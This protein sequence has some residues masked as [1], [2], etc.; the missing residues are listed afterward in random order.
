M[1][2]LM[3][4]YEFPPLGG[5]ASPAS[6]EIAKRYVR[7]GHT[8]DV[9]TMAFKNLPSFEI[10]EGINIYRIRCLRTKKEICYPWE[11]LSYIVSAKIF[12]KTFLKN[13]KYDINHTHFIIP[14]GLISLW[15]KKNY[16]LNYIITSHGS[17]VLGYNKR[18]RF[19]YPL[20]KRTWKKIIREADVVTTPSKFLQEKIKEHTTEGNFVVIPYTIDPTLF[21]PL[22][23]EKKILIVARLFVNKG[24]QDILQA[25][26]EINM[27]GWTVDIIGDGPY[28][29]FL[30]K[31]AKEN[32]L[33]T[34][35]KFHG[36]IDNK[37]E[38]MKTFYGNAAIFI[39]ASYFESM[40][41]TVLE[42]IA[43]G[44]YALVTNVGGHLDML[45][46]EYFF[47]ASNPQ[48]LKEKLI[49]LMNNWE[50]L[51][52]VTLD[53]KFNWDNIILRYEEAL[54]YGKT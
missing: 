37:S 12:L 19:I 51:K 5:G 27:T 49:P 45:T 17:D 44:C 46:D 29:N 1:N 39:S 16:R 3:L 2:I 7:L 4:N 41:L 40:G 21:T 23:K 38:V 31:K 10:K 22:S 9:V 24:V 13:K 50:E 15:V 32:G 14:T 54:Q 52:P 34:V 6:Y 48:S 26:K 53:D 30:E 25:M 35:V 36:W 28:R 47:E 42:A 20:I 33:E 18:F 8:V 11:Q 43:S